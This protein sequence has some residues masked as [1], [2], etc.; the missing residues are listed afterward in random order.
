M[1]E[2]KKERKKDLWSVGRTK[3]RVE[4]PKIPNDYKRWRKGKPFIQL[5]HSLFFAVCFCFLN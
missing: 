2:R 1:K 4:F 3:K 5:L